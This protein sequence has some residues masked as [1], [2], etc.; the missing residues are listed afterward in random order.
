[1]GE[2][3]TGDVIFLVVAMETLFR[4]QTNI[5]KRQYQ[6]GL[7]KWREISCDAETHLSTNR[8]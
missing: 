8:E 3:S 7:S 5:E 2:L 6:V 1:M 4:H